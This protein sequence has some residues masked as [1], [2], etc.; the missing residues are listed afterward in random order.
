MIARRDISASIEHGIL[1]LRPKNNAVKRKILFIMDY[2]MALGYQLWVEDAYPANH[3]WGCLELINKGYEIWLP[4]PIDGKKCNVRLKHDLFPTKLALAHFAQNDIIYCAHNLLLWSPLLKLVKLLK[5]RIVGQLYAQEPLPFHSIYDGIIAH[6]PVAEKYAL[7]FKS[8]AKVKRISWG[9]DL[10]F[11]K[12]YPYEPKWTIS[13][14]KTFRDFDVLKQAFNY[15]SIAEEFCKRPS[16]KIIMSGSMEGLPSNIDFIEAKQF[17]HYIYPKLVEEYY[18]YSSISIITMLKDARKRH[19]I[20][21]TN[22]FESMAC[23]RPVIVTKTGALPD[24]I[25]VE[26]EKIGLFIPPN[27]SH[28]LKKAI[29]RL[30]N[31]PE[32]AKQMGLRGRLLCEKYYNTERFSDEL[33]RYFDTL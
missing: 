21:L 12:A 1:I 4:K 6:T 23:G 8:R 9:M 3:L 18:R 11:F 22:L 31:E 24:E 17:G 7:Q 14:G 26:S 25:D 32:E 13:C 33:D 30:L 28:A 15:K 16:V 10:D 19:S 20:G 5:C 2:G 27:D 29:C